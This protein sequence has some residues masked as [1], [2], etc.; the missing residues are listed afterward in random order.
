MYWRNFERLT[1]EYFDRNGYAVTLG[2]GSKDGGVDIRLWPK[3]SDKTLPPL[4]LIQCKRYKQGSLVD[5]EYVKALWSDVDFE[6]AQSGLIATTARISPD[7]KRV[8]EARKYPLAFA[9]NEAVKGWTRSMWRFSWDQEKR[10]TV[11]VGN[12]LLPPVV[13]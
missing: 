1:A 10:Q 2:P 3:D 13:P 8:C 12:Y 4:M 7:G 11:G 6:G 9:E 5:V